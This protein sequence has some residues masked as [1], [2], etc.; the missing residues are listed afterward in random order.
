M[1]EL[2][3]KVAGKYSFFFSS[4]PYGAICS[5]EAWLLISK[6]QDIP[7]PVATTSILLDSYIIPYHRNICIAFLPLHTWLFCIFQL[8]HFADE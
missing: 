7:F 3:L 5:L 2:Y 8:C 6:S 4:K 1:E